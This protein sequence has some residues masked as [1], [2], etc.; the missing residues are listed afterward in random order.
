MFKSE[1]CTHTIVPNPRVDTRDRKY[2]K[3]MYKIKMRYIYRKYI[4]VYIIREIT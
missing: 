1:L 4:V 2:K 3:Y